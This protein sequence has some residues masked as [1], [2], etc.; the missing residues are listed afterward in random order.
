[1]Y[2]SKSDVESPSPNSS[3]LLLSLLSYLYSLTYDLS[4][5]SLLPVVLLFDSLCCFLVGPCFLTST[6]YVATVSL[7]STLIIKIIIRT[8]DPPHKVSVGLGIYCF[9]IRNG[10]F[11][12][13]T[14][15]CLLGLLC[16][17]PQQNLP[18]SPPIASW[19]LLFFL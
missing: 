17:Y 3:S 18:I 9:R 8:L 7:N 15:C 5:S 12:L 2:S 11:H 6:V 13:V 16:L 4:S 19:N 10:Y 14:F 1:M